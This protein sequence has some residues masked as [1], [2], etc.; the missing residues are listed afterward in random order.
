QARGGDVDV[1]AYYNSAGTTWDFYNNK[2]GRDSYNNAG[3]VLIG[4]VHYSNNYCN[5]FWN[6]TQMVY[7]D[8]N[9]S[10]CLPLARSIDV[11]AHELTHAVTENESGLIYSG[12]SGG[13]NEAMSDIFG[14]VTE[15]FVDGGKNGSLPVSN[16]TFLVGED[17]IPGGL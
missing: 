16:D 2:W 6:R 3:A 15:S 11:T 8:G 14:A 12:E 1:D 4:S 5:A 9:G 7:G 10:S 17:I 13:I